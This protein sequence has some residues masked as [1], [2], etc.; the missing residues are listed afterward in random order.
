MT[1]A[2]KNALAIAQ[3]RQTH[4][5]NKCYHYLEYKIE[6]K[7]LLSTKNINNPIDKQRPTKKLLSKYVGPYT[8]LRKISESQ[9]NS[10]DQHLPSQFLYP[11]LN[12]K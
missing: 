2:A 8:I 7:V 3:Q 12:K 4:Y 5:T 1:K 9:K 6:D 10:T 11:K